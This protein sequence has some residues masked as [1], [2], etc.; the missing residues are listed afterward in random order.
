M[1]R[2][3]QFFY[4]LIFLFRQTLQLFFR[5]S[6]CMLYLIT[7]LYN[8]T[9]DLLKSSGFFFL[10]SILSVFSGFSLFFPV[11]LFQV[12]HE[13]FVKCFLGFFQSFFRTFL[14]YP[15]KLPGRFPQLFFSSADSFPLSVV[16]DCFPLPLFFPSLFPICIFFS[17]SYLLFRFT[18]KKISMQFLHAILVPV[19]QRMHLSVSGAKA[20]SRAR[21]RYFLLSRRASTPPCGI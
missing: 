4:D 15:S 5:M 12:S 18:S 1:Y 11:E 9:F 16:R 20:T 6:D 7:E 8:C 10:F 17:M 2:I 21:V 3:F 13:F 14:P 19:L